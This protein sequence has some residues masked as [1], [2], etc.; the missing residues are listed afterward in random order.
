MIRNKFALASAKQYSNA[1][2]II[3][4]NPFILCV[5]N[6]IHGSSTSIIC[7]FFQPFIASVP[8]ILKPKISKIFLLFYSWT[9]HSKVF[10]Y[11]TVY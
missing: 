3:D 1:T 8:M 5:K 9:E 6:H 10:T 4:R 2:L 7:R 11:L